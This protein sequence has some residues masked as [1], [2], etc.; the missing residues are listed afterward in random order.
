MI[1]ADRNNNR[2]VLLDGEKGTAID[3]WTSEL[4]FDDCEKP[5]IWSV[6]VDEAARQV[7]V[8]TSSFGS[9]SS[10]PNATKAA[11]IVILSLPPASTALRASRNTATSPTNVVGYAVVTDGGFPHELCADEKTGAVLAAAV[12]TADLPVADR[13]IAAVTRYIKA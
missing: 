9:G 6:R 5:A 3:T 4:H 1:V 7:Y 13:G 11:R 2:V 8:A 12:D 10:C